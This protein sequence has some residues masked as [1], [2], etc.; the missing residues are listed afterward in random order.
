MNVTRECA[1]L[2]QVVWQNLT[3]TLTATRQ[4]C[5]Q[6]QR[7]K[8]WSQTTLCKSRSLYVRHHLHSIF[9]HIG[10]CRAADRSHHMG[11]SVFLF[12]HL[13]FVSLTSGH[14]QHQR[15]PRVPEGR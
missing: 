11:L 8:E 12:V 9:L 5:E 4:R 6:A 10:L 1:L 15:L 3:P 2:K 7:G 14:D 13:I